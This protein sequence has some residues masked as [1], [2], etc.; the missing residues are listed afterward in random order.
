MAEIIDGKKIAANILQDIGEKIKSHG[1]KPKLAV[2]LVGNDPASELYVRKKQQ[3]AEKTGID[4]MKIELPEQTTKEQL[5]N[6]INK[7]NEDATVHGIIVQL[8]LPQHLDRK[9]ILPLISFEKDVDKLTPQSL[10]RLLQGDERCAPCT[11]YGIIKMLDNVNVNVE[12]K[13]AVIINN[14]DLIGKPLALLLTNRFATATMC[15]IKTQD[16][17]AHTTT[18]DILIT[19]TG[20]PGLVT[21]DMVKDGA[22][23]VDAGISHENGKVLGDVDFDNVKEKA[24]YI[25]PVPGGV[26]PVTVAVLLEN[27]VLAAIKGK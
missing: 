23:V 13:N 16:L 12:G 1:I 24:A 20:K 4:F 6:E 14:S 19:A 27:T 17:K 21:A 3:A 11:P 22:V 10:A 9:E 18:A 5:E 15:H 26:G 2:V 25:T 7:L 8:P